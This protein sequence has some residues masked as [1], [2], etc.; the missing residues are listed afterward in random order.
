M[1]LL[2]NNGLQKTQEDGIAYCCRL[3]IPLNL[4]LSKHKKGD[5]LIEKKSFARGCKAIL[6]ENDEIWLEQEI[7]CDIGFEF[8]RYNMNYN[9]KPYKYL[10]F[11]ITWIK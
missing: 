9:L 11:N 7:L 6:K 8:P 5:N 2:R 10:W 4:D 1:T 3:V